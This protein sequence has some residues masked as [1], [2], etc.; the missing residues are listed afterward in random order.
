MA[1][2][3]GARR[4]QLRGQSRLCTA[5]P[6]HEPLAR[7]EPRQASSNCAGSAW[8]DG[9]SHAPPRGF[10]CG[11]AATP[12]PFWESM[13]VEGLNG[14]G[15]RARPRREIRTAPGNHGTYGKS[16]DGWEFMA[17]AQSGAATESRI[18][19]RFRDS[20]VSHSAGIAKIRKSRRGRIWGNG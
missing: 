10:R 12:A 1:V 20:C 17:P 16:W 2:S 8:Q 18:G 19:S 6:F 15:G 7:P 3:E 14:P 4:S 9:N 11:M 5:F 13:A